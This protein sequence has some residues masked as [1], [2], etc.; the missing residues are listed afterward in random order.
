MKQESQAKPYFSF[1]PTLFSENEDAHRLGTALNDKMKRYVTVLGYFRG[2]EIVD[3][4]FEEWLNRCISS[5]E[6]SV[7]VV[8]TCHG[9]EGTG[10]IP[11]MFQDSKFFWDENMLIFGAQVL[12]PDSILRCV[13]FKGFKYYMQMFPQITFEFIFAQCYGSFFAKQFQVHIPPFHQVIGL[14]YKTTARMVTMSPFPK[15]S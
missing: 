9:E 11:D 6:I 13:L 14:S 10:R 7:R 8:F 4:H 3:G 1:S 15:V 2:G 12:S 5:N